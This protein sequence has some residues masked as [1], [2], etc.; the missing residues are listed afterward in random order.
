MGALHI[1]PPLLFVLEY[2]LGLHRDLAAG[3]AEPCSTSLKPLV[4]LEK[5]QRDI[6]VGPASPPSSQLGSSPLCGVRSFPQTMPIGAYQLRYARLTP[7]HRG[8]STS[9]VY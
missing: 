1:E 7:A 8:G 6:Y 9:T 2:Y 5:Y 4:L 3:H